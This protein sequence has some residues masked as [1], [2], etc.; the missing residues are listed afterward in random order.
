MVQPEKSVQ[1]N[2][3]KKRIF[4]HFRMKYDMQFDKG[5][6]NM[7]RYEYFCKMHPRDNDFFY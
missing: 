7:E 4:D 1:I 5:K 2:F 3:H 6:K